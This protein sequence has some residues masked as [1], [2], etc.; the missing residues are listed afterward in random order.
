[1]H[2]LTFLFALDHPPLK[3]IWITVPP[4][5]NGAIFVNSYYGLCMECAWW[6]G[7]LF[8]S[9]W[10]SNCQDNRIGTVP[11]KLPWAFSN[12]LISRLWRFTFHHDI[13]VT[14]KIMIILI[15]IAWP[16]FS[17]LSSLC[18]PYFWPESQPW[19]VF[20]FHSC[21]R[22]PISPRLFIF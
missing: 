12:F 17:K 10:Y 5:A 7:R 21:I 6:T 18:A 9:Y 13:W 14:L 16:I 8:I 1:M 11:G 4:L 19:G 20:W 15:V 3:C 22:L 2:K